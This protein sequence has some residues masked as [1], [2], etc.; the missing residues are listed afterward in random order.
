MT[1]GN[2]TVFDLFRHRRCRQLRSALVDH[3]GG[4]AGP[5]KRVVVEAHVAACAPC[6]AALESL[7]TVPHAL[8]D[9]SPR[10]PDADFWA[11]QRRDIMRA[12]REAPAPA[13][14]N[15]SAG[16]LRRHAG[17]AA[18]VAAAAVLAYHVATGPGP[19]A[20]RSTSDGL[21]PEALLA[22]ADVAQT[23]A[24]PLELGDERSWHEDDLLIRADDL[25][26]DDL[27]ALS[28]LIGLA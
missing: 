7:R 17:L 24:Q 8:G 13:A 19:A 27:D 15:R 16:S 28:E 9:T 11:R 20:I 23:L 3:A 26:D 25:S 14:S 5:A 22:L 2:R 10:E 21:D 12:V 4:D 1:A 6:K 18:A